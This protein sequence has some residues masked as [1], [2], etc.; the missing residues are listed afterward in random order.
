MMTA[1]ATSPASKPLPLD[2]DPVIER[3]VRVVRECPAELYQA[4]TML[5]P[6]PT[7]GF[8]EGDAATLEWVG[9]IAR[10]AGDLF[11][12]WLDARAACPAAVPDAAK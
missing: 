4:P 1:C 8:L 10:A 12:Q 7:G 5:P 6:R 9:A 2:R 11:R 3:Q